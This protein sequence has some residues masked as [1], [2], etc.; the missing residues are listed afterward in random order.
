[1][2]LQTLSRPSVDADLTCFH[3]GDP[4]G[5]DAIQAHGKFFCCNGCRVVYEVLE[6]N[7]LC[8]YYTL[9]TTPGHAPVI[10]ASGKYAYLDEPTIAR[11]LIAF[12][13]GT[14][15]GVRLL[16]PGMHCASCVWLLEQL[17]AID[18]GIVESRV[19]F[20]RKEVSVQFDHSATSLRK[21]VELFSSLGYEPEINLGS[22]EQKAESSATRSL[23]AK[24]GVAGF[25]FGNIMLLSF[26]EYFATS[27]LDAGMR[28]VFDWV[29][30]GLSIP[31]FFYSAG[32]YF[33]SAWGGLRRGIV[34]IDVPLA[35]GI[36]I[37]FVRSVVD[38]AV[39]GRAGYFDSLS[40]LVFF[41]LIGKVFQ[42]KTYDRLNFDRKYTSYFPL[43]VTI[44]KLGEERAVPVTTL[45]VGDKMLLRHNEIIPCDA[46]VMNGTA[47][48]DYSFVT[49]E[50]TPVVLS[51]GACV[52]AGGRQT[53]G[54]VEMEVTKEVSQ[55]HLTQLWNRYDAE[56]DE[57]SRLL[58]LSNAVGK[59]FTVGVL[60]VA[61]AAAAWWLRQA[62]SVA[63]DAVTGILIVAC[64]CAFA[65]AAPFTYGSVLRVFGRHHF[66]LKNAQVVEA[67][68]R[69][70]TVVFDK[71]G[72][73]TH[74]RERTVTFEGEP[75]EERHR[76]LILSVARVSIHPL[77]RAIEQSLSGVPT[78]AM[79]AVEEI[80]GLGIRAVVDGAEIRIGAQSFAGPDGTGAVEESRDAARSYVSIGGLPIGAFVVRQQYRDGLMELVR[81]LGKDRRLALVSGDHRGE[82]V[83]LES[84]FPRGTEMR[85]D[86]SP[87]DKRDYV[88]SLQRDGAAV[89][90]IG[91]GLNDAG[92][93]RRSNVGIAVT[94]DVNAFS[95]ACDAILEGNSL[96]RLPA[97]LGLSRAAVRIIQVSFSVSLL[98]NVAAL[99][100]AVQGSLS[101]VLAA[102]LMPVSSVTVVAL[103][104]GLVRLASR[105]QGLAG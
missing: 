104:M 54:A 32:E 100:V 102:I 75:L 5:T 14:R 35:L 99:G 67:L 33:T 61:G 95:P 97:F 48:V 70:T 65:L 36:L 29:M 34:N 92:A 38:V 58:T 96:R 66:Y 82:R 43:A 52:Y 41:L 81:A 15:R 2:E 68:A 55:S 28:R 12:E 46:I 64:P 23:V 18:P 39:I 87:F 31:V 76:S 50:S 30:L 60:V 62:P 74:G 26:P 21:V 77:S 9:D 101:P 79:E 11:Q 56:H 80:P 53:G 6:R 105:R 16:V 7:D 89:L 49:G 57:K 59:W 20:L 91:D 51:P 1:M 85:F 63:L 69:G 93:L 8:T 86:Q 84:M 25:C 73:L 94:D 22:L 42:S 13:A 10:H 98:Y 78:L 90:M 24:V 37:L 3:C 17:Y 83:R 19:D 44:R 47:T 72:T 40:G 103:T 45:A 4:V 27:E 88:A 71:T